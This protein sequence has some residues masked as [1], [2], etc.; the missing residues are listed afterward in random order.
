MSL[1]LEIL[2]QEYPNITIQLNHSNAFELLI[3]TILSAQ[4]TD[5]RVNIVTETLF[6]KYLIPEDYINA[7]IEQIEQD[8][9]STGFYR[10]KAKN[11]KAAS[12]K[13]V[14][15]FNGEVPSN[16]DDLTSLPGVGRKTANVVLGHI[17]NIPGVVV[18]THV[19]RISKMLGFVETS[20]AVKIEYKLME[21][22]PKELWVIFTH[23]FI[24]LGRKVCIARRPQC[25]DCKI[26]HLCPSSK[27]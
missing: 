11:I 4:C 22:I 17:F 25:H 24:N 8:I 1:I 19:K 12:H 15:D 23:Y 16:I 5:A 9:F 20:D 14:N 18:D 26:S 7:P 2:S 27:I 3:A 10:A 13:L 6:K 21:L